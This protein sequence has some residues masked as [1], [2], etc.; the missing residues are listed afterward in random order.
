MPQH[1]PTSCGAMLLP[2]LRMRQLLLSMAAAPG[3][4]R[5]HSASGSRVGV[6]RCHTTLSCSALL[7]GVEASV[8]HILAGAPAS[9]TSQ[10]GKACSRCTVKPLPSSRVSW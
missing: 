5:S 7:S 1:P 2:S 3:L 4:K 9:R 10:A 6:L 8:V